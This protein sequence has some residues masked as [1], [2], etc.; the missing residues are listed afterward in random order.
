MGGLIVKYRVLILIHYLKFRKFEN[1]HLRFGF[2]DAKNP[3]E[4]FF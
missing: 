4:I 2:S 1:F 3:E